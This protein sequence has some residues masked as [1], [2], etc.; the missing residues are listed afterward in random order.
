MSVTH[1]IILNNEGKSKRKKICALK[2][3][4]Y[5]SSICNLYFSL[6]MSVWLIQHC[7]TC[8]QSSSNT[9]LAIGSG[10]VCLSRV[11]SPSIIDFATFMVWSRILLLRLVLW[12]RWW[13]K[14]GEAIS[15][16]RLELVVFAV[17]VVVVA[18]IYTLDQMYKLNV[19]SLFSSERINAVTM[20]CLFILVASSISYEVMYVHATY[21]RVLLACQFV[22]LAQCAWLQS[23][24][25]LRWTQL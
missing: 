4:L 17:V 18:W 2:S 11:S 7:G 16:S 24:L 22:Y 3:F 1:A 25:K 10:C 19:N 21:A 14:T 6:S 23:N 12:W 8:V 5:S 20:R 15:H 9:K 13:Y